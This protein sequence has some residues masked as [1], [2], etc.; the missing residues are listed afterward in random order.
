[1]VPITSILTLAL[2]VAQ[3]GS[4][5]F[6]QPAAVIEPQPNARPVPAGRWRGFNLMGRYAVQWTNTMTGFREPCFAAIADWGFNY[7]R[8]P[9]DY[10][11]YSASNDWLQFDPAGLECIDQ[12]IAW[13]Q[14]YGL[15]IDLCLHRAPGYCSHDWAGRIVRLPPE[16]DLD[17]WKDAAA[18]E[19]FIQHWKMFAR[20]YRKIDNDHLSFNLVNEPPALDPRRYA[21][22]MIQTIDAIRAVSPGR[23]IV[24]DGLDMAKQPVLDAAL[25]AMTNVIQSR[26][27]Y[28]FTR[29]MS[30]RLY[31]VPDSD[32]WPEPHW[33]PLPMS[34]KLFGHYHQDKHCDGPLVVEG[35][36]PPGTRVVLRVFQVSMPGTLVI[37]AD[38]RD[39]L[40]HEFAANAKDPEAKS[41]RLVQPWKIYQNVYDRDYTVTLAKPA[42][43]LTLQLTGSRSDWL[44]FDSLRLEM[45]GTNTV[46][47][48]LY[49]DE[50]P[51]AIYR[52]GPGWATLASFPPG[53]TRFYDLDHYLSDWKALQARGG[54]VMIGEFG[55][56]NQTPHRDALGYY[57]FLLKSFEQA[58][59][60][61]ACWDFDYPG[62]GGPVNSRRAGVD[63]EELNGFQ[64]DRPM[65][66]LMRRH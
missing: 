32:R 64:V 31:Y 39:L 52:A 59:M 10:R 18:Q 13:G 33:P 58:G 47:L 16:Q 35:D 28:D 40:K 44:S 23:L 4:T 36:F 56:S 45:P 60:G 46:L 41:I 30:Y 49:E 42:R 37:Q 50:M 38:G 6:A 25:L 48:P 5:A 66:D 43:Q 8:L 11:S 55:Q 24:V 53:A 54:R 17:L 3:A 20:R 27:C 61:W 65:L 22:L 62:G 63:Y 34:A 29:F 15:H 7:V 14:Q 2:F 9:I 51:P 12:A 1:M 21:R 57:E 26:H 19:A